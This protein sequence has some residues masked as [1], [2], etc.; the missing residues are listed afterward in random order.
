M[1]S[2]KQ[3][4]ALFVIICLVVNSF[5]SAQG[6]E[7]K[8][9]MYTISGRVEDLGGVTILGLPGSPVTNENGYYIAKVPH[10]WTG[11]ATPIKSGY[12]FSPNSRTY[13]EVIEEKAN[14][15]FTSVRI[16]CTISGSVGIQ[17]V[18][19]RGLPG[20]P[21]TDSNGLYS[22]AVPFGWAG[23]V[24]P[25][26]EGYSFDPS[27]RIYS[28]VSSD[29]TNHDYTANVLSFI[30]S[31]KT[32]I[33]GVE[34]Q[35]LPG[36]VVTGPDGSYTVTVDYGFSGTVKP[37]KEGLDFTPSNRTYSKISNNFTNQDYK[38]ASIMCNISGTTGIT[39]VEMLGLPSH[40]VTDQSGSYSVTVMYSW[41]GTVVPKKEGYTFSPA[42]MIY[43]TV[44]SDKNNQDYKAAPIVYTISGTTGIEGVRMNGLPGNP[45][46]DRNGSYSVMVEYGWMGTVGPEKRGY[47]FEPASRTYNNIVKNYNDENYVAK[48]LKYQISGTIIS[49]KG[50]PMEGIQITS[51]NII[52]VITDNKGRY[53]FEVEYGWSGLIRPESE[54]YTLTPPFVQ[55]LPVNRNISNQNYKAQIRML[56]ITDTIKLNDKPI[57]NIK[58][59]ANPGNISTVTDS[60]SRYS[61][62]VPYGWSGEIT[63]SKPGIIFEPASKSYTNITTDIIN[64]IPVQPKTSVVA[65]LQEASVEQARIDRTGDRRII[66]VPD[67]G[68]K[69]EEIAQT[70]EDILVMAE[71]LDERFREPR[72]IEGVLRDFGDF[73]G[74]DNQQT[75]AIYIQGYGVIFMIEVNYNFSSLSQ[76]ATDS[77]E[78]KNNDTDQTWDKARQKVLSPGMSSTGTQASAGEYEKQMVEILKTELIRTLK[79][80]ANIRNIKPDEWVILSVSGTNRQPRLLIGSGYDG[81]YGSYD[82][83]YGGG[84]MG[85]YGGG[86]MGG[87]G[88][89]TMGGY[90][91]GAPSPSEM[92]GGY[93][94]GGGSNYGETRGGYGGGMM[95]GMMGGYGASSPAGMMGGYGNLRERFFP[96]S[97]AANIMTMR[98]KKSD[99]D[100]FA[101]EK[102]DFE[103]FREKV[104]I[105]I[106]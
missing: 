57:Q 39:G 5:V 103:Q 55:Y 9:I 48:I 31:G 18:V 65:T 74:R 42:S 77:N 72:L 34:M 87:Y 98:V 61:I 76:A 75:E 53:A 88:S 91:G 63:F 66:I 80:A 11:T 2:F 100:E 46:T 15:D 43:K 99:V 83:S 94:Y 24:S 36:Y 79:Y 23:N 12:T 58:V 68:I 47:S 13:T 30:I 101:N 78:I 90:G 56:T 102:I 50:Y 71:I 105:L 19:M 20:H 104:Q 28:A 70:K 92:R 7:S 69:S 6:T 93:G 4:I 54:Q 14:Q 22:V 38:A 89:S 73:F 40:V 85:G 44:V 64:G 33:Q 84:M 1:K 21:V 17:G 10:N 37:V 67:Q 41:S 16:N 106:N 60:R 96:R 81:I 8:P 59:D 3:T 82:D 32:G 49:D 27:K 51:E 45:V 97:L 86:M 29:Y 52:P 25:S 26:M 35:G 62:Q 95:G